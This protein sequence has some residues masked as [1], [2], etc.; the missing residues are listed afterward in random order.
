MSLESATAWKSLTTAIIHESLDDLISSKRQANAFLLGVT[1]SQP[2]GPINPLCL[3]ICQGLPTCKG[4]KVESL[5]AHIYIERRGI[6]L[7][8]INPGCTTANLG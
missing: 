6:V 3:R 4:K 1:K 8:P 5:I 2:L 7:I